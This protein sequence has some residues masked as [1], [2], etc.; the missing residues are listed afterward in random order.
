MRQPV[1]PGQLVGKCPHRYTRHPH[2]VNF[3][4]NRYI[5][6]M[7]KTL[8]SFS[9]GYVVLAVAALAQQ[10]GEKAAAP[11]KPLTPTLSPEGRGSQKGTEKATA[12][13]KPSTTG[14]PSAQEKGGPSSKK[15][16]AAEKA[17]A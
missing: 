17:E 2:P 16:K 14:K 1:S 3:Q 5:Q 7:R 11:A 15:P 4:K 13:E 9:V 6:H 10:Q 12:Q 8:A